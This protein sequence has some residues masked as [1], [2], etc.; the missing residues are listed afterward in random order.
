MAKK[1][2]YTTDQIDMMVETYT[3]AETEDERKS[4]VAEIA[5]RI[6]YSIPAIRA[7]LVH[8]GV[9]VAANTKKVAKERGANKA[10]RA[11]DIGARMGLNADDSKSLKFVTVKVMDT[12]DRVLNDL[13]DLE[14]ESMNRDFS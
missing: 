13:E 10:D 6:G 7:K 5:T 12:L 11:V 8:L 9:Y 2:K 1:A 14:Q 4:A 3:S